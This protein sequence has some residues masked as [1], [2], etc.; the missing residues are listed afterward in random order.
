MSTQTNET[1]ARATYSFERAR[2]ALVATPDV[3]VE[4]SGSGGLGNGF[5]TVH[6]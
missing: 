3:G 5:A 1:A 6:G 4:N 2:A